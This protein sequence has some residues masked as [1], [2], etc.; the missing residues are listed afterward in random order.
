[1]HF[2]YIIKSLNRDLLYIG[3]TANIRK[4]LQ[5]HNNGA[6]FTTNKYKPWK[7]VYLEGYLSAEDAKYREKM[8]KHFGRVYSQLKRRI[9]DSLDCA[10]KVRG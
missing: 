1:M 4:R 10:E 7:L 2:V 3:Y 5:D 6:S 8:L 9:K